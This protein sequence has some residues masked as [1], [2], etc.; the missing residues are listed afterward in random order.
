[1]EQRKVFAKAS[2]KSDNYSD[3]LVIDVSDLGFVPLREDSRKC[4]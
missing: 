4:N 1:M 3:V 2:D